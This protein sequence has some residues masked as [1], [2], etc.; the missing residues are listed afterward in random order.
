MRAS[1]DE[2]EE[3]RFDVLAELLG[4]TA[5][6]AITPDELTILQTPV[7]QIPEENEV[8]VILAAEAFGVIGKACGLF[9][10]LPMPP[11]PVA[12][13]EDVLESILQMT[14]KEI[15]ERIALPDEEAAADILEVVEVIHWRA[16]VEFGARLN[17]GELT[18]EEKE[19][20]E[21]VGVE[22]KASGL[23]PIYPSGDLKLGTN[24]SENGVTMKW[25]PSTSFL[26]SSAPLSNGSATPVRNGPSSPTRTRNSVRR[27][28]GH[29]ARTPGCAPAI[30]LR[31]SRPHC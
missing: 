5:A 29:F 1:A 7:A 19:S 9:N 4:S 22:S 20:I 21:A 6:D 27:Q 15:D 25:K 8:A 17:G 3:R 16:D 30:S 2:I 24:R 18:P 23:L 10:D 14:L 28:P 12:S 31:R 11:N 26:S 13:S